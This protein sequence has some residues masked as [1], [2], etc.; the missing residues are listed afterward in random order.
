MCIQN[1]K[2]SLTCDK[3]TFLTWK[4]H[5]LHDFDANH[6]PPLRPCPIHWHLWSLC[7][8]KHYSLYCFCSM[9]TL[10]WLTHKHSQLSHAVY[11]LALTAFNTAVPV[12][13]TRSDSR[14]ICRSWLTANQ[15]IKCRA[16]D[17]CAI[18]SAQQ[19]V[20]LLWLLK[21]DAEAGGNDLCW[22]WMPWLSL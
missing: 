9:R 1:I 15:S 20:S 12:Y 11:T 13:I 4:A 7:R 2:G 22:I 6:C 10:Q 18:S 17:A 19:L 16:R 5:D 8:S 3:A 14:C 21:L